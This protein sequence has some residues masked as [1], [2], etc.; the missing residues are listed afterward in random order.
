MAKGEATR[1]D[2][3][4]NTHASSNTSDLAWN[5][6][7]WGATWTYTTPDTSDT[8][9]YD[10]GNGTEYLIKVYP[11]DPNLS[12]QS[13][14]LLTRLVV[15]GRPCSSVSATGACLTGSTDRSTWRTIETLLRPSS[16][17][18]FQTFTATFLSYGSGA[19]TYGP[20]FV[21]QDKN[22]VAGH[23]NHDGKAQANLY[24]QERV[25]G[26]HDP[27]ERCEEVQTRTARRPLCA[28]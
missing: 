27:T 25:N 20:I 21:G 1:T 23:L 22:G 14:Q 28:R 17:A 10:V 19:T 4:G 24:A 2:K 8:G 15:I 18:D 7:S 5:S 26:Q 3:N 13:A 12:S 9:W 11:A 6:A 16:L